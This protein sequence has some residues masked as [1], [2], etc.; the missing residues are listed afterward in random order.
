MNTHVITLLE[1]QDKPLSSQETLGA[2][3]DIDAINVWLQTSAANSVHTFYSYR[4]EAYRFVLFCESL[5]KKLIE[6]T[7]QDIN[8][9]LNLLLAPPATWPDATYLN[10]IEESTETKK[11][12]QPVSVAY[13]KVV[14]QSMYHF[15]LNSGHVRH[16]PFVL[17]RKIRYSQQ[18][19]R[20]KALSLSAWLFIRDWLKTQ[21]EDAIKNDQHLLAIRNRWLMNLLY[22]TGMRRSSLVSTTM[23]SFT[24]KYIK[25]EHIWSLSFDTKGNRIHSVIVSEALL[26]ELVFYRENLGLSP[27]PSPDEEMPLILAIKTGKYQYER[28]GQGISVRGINYAFEQMK[29][30]MI[31]D[32][33]DAYLAQE[34]TQMTPHTLRHTCATHRLMAG[35]SLESTQ[36][37]LGHRQITT[38]MIYSHINDESLLQEQLK[39]DS[40]NANQS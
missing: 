15:L 23:G 40:F 18:D 14:L 37:T 33:D 30:A 10:G 24:K 3:N 8:N 16:N 1:P 22:H 13:A 7:A 36:R 34:L 26:K 32:C 27:Y 2:H 39:F 9:Y 35:A 25:N 21:T 5:N 28:N 12:L 6:M 20:D 4:K 29:S 38:T 11:P 17:S 31:L 19:T